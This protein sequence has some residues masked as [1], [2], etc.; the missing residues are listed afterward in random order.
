MP[1]TSDQCR[2]ARG[3]LNWT[4]DELATNARVSRA[5]V[6]DFESNSRRPMTNNILAIE[7]SMF[8]AGIEFIPEDGTDGAG[9]RFRQRTLQYV[10]TVKVDMFK[11]EATMPMVYCGNE[12]L[13]IV[14]REVLEDHLHT[15][16]R[17]E[18]EYTRAFSEMLHHIL[19][20]VEKQV[21]LGFDGERFVVRSEM[22]DHALQ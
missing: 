2:A 6:A 10:K 4:Q 3:L 11:G 18:A 15:N 1:I 20:A 17:T 7:D 9:V 21:R 13:C 16:F 14:P 5:T 8:A 19:A 12:F 22:F